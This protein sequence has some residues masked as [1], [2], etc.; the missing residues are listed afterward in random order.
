MKNK[1][2]KTILWILF[3]LYIL[4]LI[5]VILFKY[6][7][8][9]EILKN[10]NMANLKRRILYFSNFIPFRTI[11]EYS[12]GDI[13]FNISVSNILGNIIAFMPLGFLL[14][15]LKERLKE[16]KK[17]FKI[18]FI[19]SLTFEVIQLITGL[20]QFDVD[21]IILNVLGGVLGFLI[22]KIFYKIYDH[23]FVANKNK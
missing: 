2:F 4:L 11:Y 5:K 9:V 1:T 14:P 3:C 12:T 20:G 8:S 6:P 10:N 22:Y 16:L 13:G 23:S 18:A 7:M 15:L 19:I 21:D 17:I